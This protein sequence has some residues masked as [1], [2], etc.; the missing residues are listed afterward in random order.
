MHG[1]CIDKVRGNE[2]MQLDMPIGARGPLYCGG[3]GKAMLAYMS[4]SDQER[5]LAGNLAALTPNTII[6]PTR[7]APRSSASGQR[8]Y[9]I[10][11]QEV[12]IGVFCVA[13]PILDRLGSP[14]GRPQ[15][16]RA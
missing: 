16:L 11:D 15:H 5:V 9:S 12:V 3:A 10:D 8:G 6:D 14:V 2:G 7:S 1:V 13:V 4:E